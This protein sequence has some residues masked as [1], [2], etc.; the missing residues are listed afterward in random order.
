[1]E[2]A[3]GKLKTALR[4]AGA[5]TRKGLDAAIASALS[6]VTPADAAGW[7]AHCGYDPNHQPT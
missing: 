7:F 1:V 3:F 4:A 6:A 2:E 5:R